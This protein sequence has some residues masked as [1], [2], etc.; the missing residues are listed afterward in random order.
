MRWN[1]L[2]AAAV[3]G[4]SIIVTAV[5]ACSD[6]PACQPGQLVLQVGLLDNS[7]LADTIRVTATDQNIPLDVTFPHV[8]NQDAAL[9]G[10]EH[11]DETVTFPNGYPGDQVVHLLV[12]ALQG[13]TVIGANTATIHLDP[14][15]SVGGVAVR[16]GILPTDMGPTD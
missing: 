5:V 6:T 4:L 7:P 11:I 14:S 3:L 12:R 15:C 1:L 10:V 8:P 16:G 13:T 2:V 9:A